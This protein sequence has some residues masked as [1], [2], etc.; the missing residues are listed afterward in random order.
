MANFVI[1]NKANID[2][3]ETYLKNKGFTIKHSFEGSTVKNVS[4]EITNNI[5]YLVF[6]DTKVLENAIKEINNLKEIN[7]LDGEYIVTSN[8]IFWKNTK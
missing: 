7:I 3:V 4:G 5:V 1:I 8:N 6:D 2:K